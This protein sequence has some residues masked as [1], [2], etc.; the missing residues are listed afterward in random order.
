VTVVSC[1]R[2]EQKL[3]ALTF[4]DGPGPDTADLLDVL[5]DSGVRVTFFVRGVAVDEDTEAL[6]RRAF[7]AGHE[8]A[9]H[10][11]SH[12][13]KLGDREPALVDE[14]IL[15]T[16]RLLAKITGT[17]PTLIR[18]PYG[19]CLGEIDRAAGRLGY[20]ATVHWSVMPRDWE[21]PGA[22]VI[23]GDVL[24]EVHP[25]A[26][27]VMHDGSTPSREVHSRAQTVEAVRTLVPALR[28]RGFELVTV[29]ELLAAG[30]PRRP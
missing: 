25:G 19:H 9:N 20:A 12:L 1:V 14:E 26:I 6:V 4:D 29:S 17:D 22:R 3:V 24:A 11:H 23:A 5:D 13:G 27:V 21:Q 2:T 16:H 18:P 8:I 7:A 10:T 28:L 15:R 30:E